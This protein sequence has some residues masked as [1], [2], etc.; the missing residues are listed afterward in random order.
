[1]S[2][3]VRILVI[4]NY[5]SFVYTIVAYLRTLG[6]EVDVT[7]NDALPTTEGGTLAPD[8]L[9]G[10]DGVLISPGPGTP[11]QAG[12]SENVIRLCASSRIPMFGV[13]LG[14]QAFADV[15][16]AKVDHAA[17]IKHGKT[18]IVEHVDD[19][20][21]RGVANP[22]TAA[23]Y[24]SLAVMADSVPDELQ[25]TA[26]SLDDHTVQGL[27]H[28][29]LPMYTVQFHPESVMTQDGYRIL[30]NW[31]QVCGSATAVECSQGLRPKVAQAAK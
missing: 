20:I 4:D 8:V 7:R 24:H 12:L 19:E 22:L 13:C 1:M 5:D 16:G 29:S 30:A 9:D 17:R 3:T 26:W 21:F 27:K 28:R 10:Y 23:R 2:E 11:D 18:S 6:A 25:V 15:F 31:L 14:L